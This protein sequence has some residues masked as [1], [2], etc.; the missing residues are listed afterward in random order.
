MKYYLIRIYKDYTEIVDGFASL[1]DCL[2][3]MKL[4]MDIC[5]TW[6]V[7]GRLAHG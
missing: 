2:G 1:N 5:T 6:D 3:A 4:K 7:I